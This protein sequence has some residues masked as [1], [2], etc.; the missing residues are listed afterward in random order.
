MPSLPADEDFPRTA[1]GLSALLA[2]A[3]LADVECQALD[4]SHRVDA[5]AW[6][7]GATNGVA[8]IGYIIERLDAAS[9]ARMKARYDAL[10]ARY[11][12]ADGLLSLPTTA[13][14]AAGTAR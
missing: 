9:V 13:L 4:W 7:A 8:T 14:L 2:G 1:D 5:E 3:G 6:W 12:A 11:L 10:S